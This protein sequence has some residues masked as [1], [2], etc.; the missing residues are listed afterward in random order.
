MKTNR[1]TARLEAIHSKRDANGN[2]YWAMRFVDYATGKVV[3]GTISG[4][5]GNINGI[6]YG[7]SDPRDYDHSIEY[8]AVEMGIR[9]FNRLTKNW[10]HVECGSED[11]QKFIKDTLAAG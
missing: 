9:D 11:L 6:R 4:G 8:V 5:E 7:W 10:P 2:T 3:V 1:L